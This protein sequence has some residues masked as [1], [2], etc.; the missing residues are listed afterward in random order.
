MDSVDS[1]ECYE[2]EPELCGPVPRTV[3]YQPRLQA[4][5]IALTLFFAAGPVFL[6]WV[7]LTGLRD[8]RTLV[9]DGQATTATITRRHVS[10]GKSTN[11]YIDY[12]FVDRGGTQR[13]GSTSVREEEYRSTHVGDQRLVTY[14]AN[15][16][17]VRVMGRVD[18]KRLR[19]AERFAGVT[20]CGVLVIFGWPLVYL[21]RF[22]AAKLRLLRN[23]LAVP[24]HIEK[25]WMSQATRTSGPYR[26]ECMAALPSGQ[27]F[28]YRTALSLQAGRALEG[29]SSITIIVDPARPTESTLYVELARS[30]AIVRT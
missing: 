19:D 26:I 27:E 28:T 20:F 15:N 1:A 17:A 4:T 29:K 25:L 16:P 8:L 23:G 24:A 30:V 2:A 3:R 9:A 22:W 6:A 14:S 5:R 18:L 13:D 12:Q 10:R 7:M 11:Y 21:H